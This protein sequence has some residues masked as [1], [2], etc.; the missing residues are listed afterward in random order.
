MCYRIIHLNKF[1]VYSSWRYRVYLTLS[2]D[3]EQDQL[4]QRKR[5]SSFEFL[6]GQTP[7]VRPTPNHRTER[8]GKGFILAAYF[9]FDSVRLGLR[10]RDMLL[11]CISSY[12]QAMLSSLLE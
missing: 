8:S 10:T 3:R 1:C 4:N 12:Y 11:I 7:E 9:N 6:L 2:S 5:Q